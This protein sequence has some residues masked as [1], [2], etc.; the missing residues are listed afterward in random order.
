MPK[1]LF[2]FIMVFVKK[3]LFELYMGKLLA[4]PLWIKQAIYYRLYLNMQENYCERFVVKNAD[5]LFAFYSPTITFKGKT[6]LWDRKSGLD[7]NIYNFLRLC[8]EG[9][10]I[11]EVSL[12]TFLSIEE[13]AKHFMFCLEQ[14]YIEKPDNDEIYAMGG[15]IAGKFRTGEYYKLNGSITID[16]LD[17]A[18]MTQRNLDGR[19]EHKLFGKIL[20]D[21]GFIT[22]K[23][24]Q[25]LFTLKADAKKRFILDYSLVPKSELV[26]SEKEKLEA[27]IELLEKANDALK[28]KMNHLLC[29]INHKDENDIDD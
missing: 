13:V 11:L 5:N 20:V 28:R 1:F 24:V 21:L 14:N 19:M 29:I 18:I 2:L 22:E 15:F 3:N 17:M 6:E 8:S 7:T 26:Q 25:T 12:N 9:Y 10:S 4:Y 23:N 27:K 16:Q